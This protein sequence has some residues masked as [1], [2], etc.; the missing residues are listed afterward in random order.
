[1]S[2]R[3]PDPPWAEPD[4][5]EDL[6]FARLARASY[7]SREEIM[8]SMIGAPSQPFRLPTNWS[9]LGKDELHHPDNFRSNPDT[10]FTAATFEQEA[11]YRQRLVV[12]VRGSDEL[13]DWAWNPLK[14]AEPAGPN[15]ALAADGNLVGLVTGLPMGDKTKE[16]IAWL[17]QKPLPD[18][19]P[20]FDDLLDY[21]LEI[22]RK[23]GDKGYEIEVTGHSLGGAGAQLLSHTFGWG[24]RTFDPAGA[25]N[26]LA[27][28]GYEKWLGR[29]GIT[30]KGAPA[31]DPQRPQNTGLLNYT[32]NDSVPSQNTGPH[33]GAT[34]PITALGGRENIEDYMK[35][36]VS[37]LAGLPL[38]GPAVARAA[39]IGGP[40]VSMVMKGTSEGLDATE[41]HDM[42]RIVRVFESAAE[43]DK[44]QQWGQTDPD[45]PGLQPS[46][47]AG[48]G[49]SPT[50][51]LLDRAFDAYM[52]NDDRAFSKV[53]DEYRQT[54][55][56]LAWAQE[57]AQFSA[58]LRE[59]ER[60][61]AQQRES[62][63][64]E[65]QRMARQG[66]VMR[67]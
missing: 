51:D 32:V 9:L 57:Q 16:Q 37:K 45:A 43:K 58:S 31:Y 62:Q 64:A 5:T 50:D 7:G 17:Q 63:Q 53:M 35:Y 61:E 30:P 60:I 12:A 49:R 54:P 66:P 52:S 8:A 3:I 20:A 19:S 25:Q 42:D 40:W 24:G 21:G 28:E 13:A 34:E 23:Y 11:L 15:V 18:W 39:G 26:I 59:Q 56:G 41:R 36:G 10:S 55:D 22:Q 67:M 65:Q 4:Y 2:D 47:R 38:A 1:M 33:I 48:K 46:L 27:S 6:M 14:P 29:N 44:L